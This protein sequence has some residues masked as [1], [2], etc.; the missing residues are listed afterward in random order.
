M[1]EGFDDNDDSLFEDDDVSVVV[2]STADTAEDDQKQVATPKDRI[3]QNESRA[4]GLVRVLVFTLLV[5]I[6][7]G[8][9]VGVYFYVR[10]QETA[11]FE[12]DFHDSSDKAFDS[13]GSVFDQALGA[14][15]NLMENAVSHQTFTN[16]SWPFVT[17]PD[18]AVKA[19]KILTLSRA[20]IIGIYP[21]VLHEDREQWEEYAYENQ[22]WVM[23]SLQIQKENAYFKGTNLDGF[24]DFPHIHT[25]EGISPN[26][27]KYYPTWQTSPTIPRWAAW[28]WD[29]LDYNTDELL[30]VENSRRVVMGKTV[31]L[32]PLKQADVDWISDYVGAKDIDPT[33][34]YFPFYYPIVGNATDAV[35]V[36]SLDPETHQIVGVIATTVIWRRI[37]EDLLSPGSQGLVAVIGNDCNQSFTYQING[38]DV[39]YLGP[40]DLHDTE[41]DK[42]GKHSYMAALGAKSLRKRQYTGFQLSTD[43]CPYWIN[44]YPSAK[45]QEQH[46]SNDPIVF[47][48]VTISIF[49]FT[50]LFF[51]VYDCVSERRQ[52][53]VLQVAEQSNAVV[54]SL[55]P[56]VIRDRIF[57]THQTNAGTKERMSTAKLRLQQYLKHDEEGLNVALEHNV[58]E[59]I[60]IAELFSDT[61]VMFLDIA[62]FTAWSSVRE[63]TQVFTLLET[64]YGSYDRL[65]SRRGVFKVE[66][67]GDSYVAVA[68]LPEPRADHAVVMAKFAR[69]VREKTVELVKKLGITLGPDTADLRIRIGLNSGPVTA[70][71]L[72]GER[73]RFQLFGDTVNTAAR[74]ESTGIVSKIQIS[75][76]TADLLKKA[77][78]GHWI[79]K[80]EGKVEAKG[81]G[82][83]QTYW[84]EPTAHGPSQTLGNEPVDYLEVEAMNEKTRR[85]VDWNVEILVKLLK[86]IVSRREAQEAIGR[87]RSKSF[88]E[89]DQING[90]ARSGSMLDEVKEVIMLPE[91]DS[92]LV[93]TPRI[94]QQINLS[95]AVMAQ[96]REYVSVIATMYPSNPFHN[97]EHASHVTMSV[98][99]LL[100]RI[101]A[102]CEQVILT[103]EEFRGAAAFES[104]LHDHTYG[105]T[106][107]PLTQFACVFSALIHD[108]DHPG[109]PN[110]QLVNEKSPLAVKYNGTSIAE[111][112]SVDLSWGLLMDGRFEDLREIICCSKSEM[113]RFRQLVVNAV[114][115]TDIM[116]GNLKSLRNQRWDKAFSEGSRLGESRMVN[117]NRKATIVIEHL[118]QASDVAHTMQHWHIFRKW[119]ERLFDE[120]YIAY[121]QGRAEKNPAEFWYKGE[122]GFFDFYIIPLAKK[123]SECGVFGVSSDEYLSYAT[124][125]REEW[126]NRGLDVVATMISKYEVPHQLVTGDREGLGDEERGNTNG[127][128]ASPAQDDKEDNT[129]SNSI[130]KALLVQKDVKE[131]TNL[132]SV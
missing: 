131:N 87:K 80:R 120:M 79:T 101:I 103:A 81:K 105:I 26:N 9:A 17:I 16:S 107:D 85:L 48:M 69:D 84:V 51:L 31:N 43:F 22:G 62:G 73:S 11:S 18:F 72:R 46:Q 56:Q 108:V 99:K 96:I 130:D 126:E 82:M 7:A 42:F 38:P 4:V 98:V 74:M 97:F 21:R 106:S 10:N 90:M 123:L 70:G 86:Q 125:N 45:M 66:T 94:P 67:I 14:S 95:T 121:K 64:L 49:M 58:V 25:N 53:K 110:M 28:G 117:T 3:A 112:N 36:A 2:E 57:R 65:A 50:A 6:T 129:A 39:L 76:S 40:G 71:V 78:K 111:Q 29:L 114:M 34:P 27:S 127:I 68:G 100:S 116:D 75:Q 60:P 52:K 47:T 24:N 37:F 128:E 12:G 61:T 15:D 113:A 118:I 30:A 89:A 1:T 77:G 59:N 132:L 91:F 102:P 124:K 93:K 104:T 32:P 119:N 35:S 55:F 83:I 115:A 23:K 20:S 5:A 54:S 13:I 44:L 88:L 19:Q 63:P 41:Y 8:V 122:L 33:E 92:S 109:V